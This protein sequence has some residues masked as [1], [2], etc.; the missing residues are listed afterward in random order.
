[1]HDLAVTARG[2]SARW[3]GAADA[4]GLADKSGVVNAFRVAAATLLVG[5]NVSAD[6]IVAFDTYDRVLDARSLAIHRAGGDTVNGL[7]EF[8]SRSW[9]PRREAFEDLWIDGRVAVYG[10]LTPG[11]GG[12][13]AGFGP[14]QLVMAEP[15]DGEQAALFP[16]D[17]AQRYTDD[18]AVVN[19]AL[20][21]SEATEWGVRSEM[22]TTE[23]GTQ[24]MAAPPAQW[25]ALM[26][27]ADDY[28]EVVFLESIPLE[29]V[30]AVNVKKS[31]AVSMRS[32]RARA[33]KGDAMIATDS[34]LAG[35]AEVLARWRRTL[36]ITLRETED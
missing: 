33:A 1:M 16:G 35:V 11:S 21:L 24:A 25:D 29:R 13:T 23:R 2:N 26:Q 15:A 7:A 4:A 31:L 12:L 27:N 30:T 5:S 6:K 9:T 14:F 22:V 36:G 20:A 34:Q 17:S 19:E 3:V 8:N 10:A 28:F 18:T 32:A